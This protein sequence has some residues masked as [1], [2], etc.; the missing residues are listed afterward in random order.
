MT[1]CFRSDD[2]VGR[3]LVMYTKEYRVDFGSVRAPNKAGFSVA[4]ARTS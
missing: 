4:V 2:C 3:S 1:R